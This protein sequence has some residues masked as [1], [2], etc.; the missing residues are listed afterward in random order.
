[1]GRLRIP[2][3]IIIGLAVGIALGLYIGWEAIPTEFVDASPVYL[4]EEQKQD[5]ARMIAAVYAVEGDL[6][7]AQ[8]RLDDLGPDGEDVLTAVMLDSILLQQNPTE[9][10]QLVNLAAML[11]IVSP[12]MDPYLSPTEEPA[13]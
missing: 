3:F 4:V 10:R 2:L 13:S 12:A 11:G 5:Y 6:T 1:M 8:Q 9:I 7:A